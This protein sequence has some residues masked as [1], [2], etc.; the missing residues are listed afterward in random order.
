MTARKVVGWVFVLIFVILAFLLARVLTSTP[1]QPDP[2]PSLEPQK[3]VSIPVKTEKKRVL[4]ARRS[5][6]AG[7]RIGKHDITWQEVNVSGY[8]WFFKH[9]DH[10]LSDFKNSVITHDIVAGQP[11]GI[12]QIIQPNQPGYLSA[13]LSPGKRAVSIP[14]D[15]VSA[16]SGLINPGDNVDLLL[17][18]YTDSDKGERAMKKGGNITMLANKVLATAIKVIAI[19]QRSLEQPSK[20]LGEFLST[21]TLEVSPKQAQALALATRMGVVSLSLRSQHSPDNQISKSELYSRDVHSSVDQL[22]PDLGLVLMRGSDT[23][24][25]GFEQ[26]DDNTQNNEESE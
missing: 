4:I 26:Q 9:D 13:V 20:E 14:I 2:T 12:G 11:I 21:A 7:E 23:K 8:G 1:K 15:D 6:T 18:F 16:S 17:T 22:K 10:R 19:N 3:A 24:V 5:I 25:V